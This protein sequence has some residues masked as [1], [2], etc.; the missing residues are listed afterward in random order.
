AAGALFARAIAAEP[1]FAR[2]HAGRSFVQFQNAFLR[3]LPDAASAVREARRSAERSIELDP[4]DPFA[5]LVMG[6]SL[7]LEGDLD[8]SSAWLERATTISPSYAQAIYARAW[9]HALSGRGPEGKADA[10]VAMA[11]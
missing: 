9:R 5:N 8:G 7:W 11:L 2:A 10:D 6:R 4:L 1:G 3:Y